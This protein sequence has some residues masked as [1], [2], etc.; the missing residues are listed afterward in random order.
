VYQAHLGGL[1]TP[2]HLGDKAY[3]AYLV[4][5]ETM[6]ISTMKYVLILDSAISLY[7]RWKYIFL[8]T[9][10]KLEKT[11]LGQTKMMN[12]FQTEGVVITKELITKKDHYCTNNCCNLA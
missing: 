11:D 2:C 5:F 12:I 7:L 9:W 10:S 4:A 8:Q 1:V 6:T 3:P